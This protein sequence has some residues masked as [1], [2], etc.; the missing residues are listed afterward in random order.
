MM[1]KKSELGK[2]SICWQGSLQN[3]LFHYKFCNCFPL[4]LQWKSPFWS[5]LRMVPA[6]C[7]VYSIRN[8]PNFRPFLQR[9]PCWSTNH[10]EDVFFLDGSQ[11]LRLVLSYWETE[12]VMMQNQGWSCGLCPS[13]E[14]FESS[15]CG[16]GILLKQWWP[17]NFMMPFQNRLVKCFLATGRSPRQL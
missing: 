3:G 17:F 14:G 11:D 13:K 6:H 10:T 1:W 16:P 12:V 9:M 4:N 15:I 8:F 2:K 5:S 7:D